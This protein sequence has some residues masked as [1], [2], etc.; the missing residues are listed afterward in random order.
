MNKTTNIS[1]SCPQ[2][3]STHFQSNTINF[4]VVCTVG[5]S[6]TISLPKESAMRDIYI[7]VSI[8]TSLSKTF[9]KLS[10]EQPQKLPD[11]LSPIEE[12]K[13][14]N[15]SKLYMS[16]NIQSGIMSEFESM[17]PARR[18]IRSY[19][20]AMSPAE[21]KDFF[22][23][24]HRLCI[25]IPVSPVSTGTLKF[26]LDE[27]MNTEPEFY[28]ES[29]E[30]MYD[31]GKTHYIHSLTKTGEKSVKGKFDG[32]LAVDVFNSKGVPGRSVDTLIS[33]LESLLSAHGY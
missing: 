30:R 33:I 7:E 2:N 15:G 8:K 21:V 32:D 11:N 16:V 1:N 28:A 4:T 3:K 10:T 5:E 6:F 19:V 9:F 20:M 12:F 22:N 31:I 18:A 14:I 23:A 17:S 26:S 27:P 29:L 24:T 25:K 13:L